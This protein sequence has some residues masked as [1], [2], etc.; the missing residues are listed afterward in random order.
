MHINDVMMSIDIFD[1][2]SQLNVQE[3]KLRMLT[4]PYI[5]IR[6]TVHGVQLN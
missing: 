4:I 6:T 3:L 5:F 1:F 2:Y